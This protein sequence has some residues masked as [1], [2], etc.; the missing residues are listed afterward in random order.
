MKIGL[1]EITGGGFIPPHADSKYFG[2]LTIFLNR[3]WEK[4]WGGWAM[5]YDDDGF[6]ASSPEYG[7]GVFY[8][9]PL[10]HCTSPVYQ[11][12][13]VRRSLQIFFVKDDTWDSEVDKRNF[14][15]WDE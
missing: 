7:H 14:V 8:R 13:Q 10:Q 12:D 4:A 2:G 1:H 6:Y 5:A 11:S 9:T 15:N 3:S